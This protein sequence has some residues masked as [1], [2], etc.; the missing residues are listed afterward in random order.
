M[1]KIQSFFANTRSDLLS[2]II[3][4]LIALPLCLGIAQASNAP[5]LSGIVSGVIGGVVIGILSKS[6]VSVSGPA[7]GLVAIVIVAIQQLGAFD[8]FL[9]AVV[10]AG[11]IQ[12]LLGLFKAGGIAGYFP[13]NVIAG[14]LAGIGLTIIIQQIPDA[15]GTVKGAG[16]TGYFSS[17]SN[18]LPGSALIALLGLLIL[19]LW[20]V[21]SLGKVR[22]I[23][24][25]LLVVVVGTVL[26][27][28]F[29]QLAP[30]FFVSGNQLVQLPVPESAAAFFGQFALPDVK[31]FSNPLVW[32]TG[33]VIAVVASIETLLCIEATDKLDPFKRQTSGNSELRAQGIGNMISGLVGGLPITSVIV[34]SSANINAGAR[35]KLSAI[36]HGVLLLVCVATVP[37]ILNLIPKATLAAILIF[38]GYKLCKPALFG[39][40]W[41]AGMAQFLPFLV[42]TI[43]VVGLDLLKGVG[44]GLAFAIVYL[45]RNNMKVPYF[46]QRKVYP[47]GEVV[48]LSLAQEVSFLNKTT[49]K[50]TLDSL[51]N[52]SELIIDANGA[53]YVDH[54]VLELIKEF[55]AA[56][57]KERH[58]KV[59]ICGFKNLYKLSPLIP[60]AG[61]Q[62]EIKDP[63]LRVS[64]GK[65]RKLLKQ[66]AEV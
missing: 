6:H 60:E 22:L 40:M 27:Q 1:S 26:N 14:M 58:I 50:R 62:P 41:K 30:G 61:T 20:E 18:I 25:G 37:F 45:L 43:G 7:A 11:V 23:P 57:A 54:D 64:A 56:G 12:L 29:A 8:I 51:P 42:T 28:L 47:E 55:Q 16:F 10:V 63:P 53:A 39:R 32:Q 46:F 2:G 13:S 4:F 49:I 48:Q 35:T 66:L 52:N 34:R 31:G 19:G 24:A 65:H 15:L 44:L 5:L 59:E 17:F 3:V 38:T 9:C 21:K 33:I 36:T